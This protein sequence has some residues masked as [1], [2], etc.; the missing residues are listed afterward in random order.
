[1]RTVI[2]GAGAA[3]IS[4]ADELAK[5][6]PWE[7]ITVVARDEFP[8]SRCMLH[9]YLEG[10]REKGQLTFVEE[11]FFAKRGIIFR[12]SEDVLSI[13]PKDRSV[14]TNKGSVFYDKLLIAAGS[15]YFIPPIPNF[16]TATNVYGFRNLKDVVLLKK[17]CK[18]GKSVVIIGSGLI[19]MDIA[20]ACSGMGMDIVVV[21][22]AKRIMPLQTD[23]IS[24]RRYQK[25]FEQSGVRFRL[26]V[27]A[28]DTVVDQEG[29][30]RQIILSDG[31]VLACD[32]VVVA[33]GVHPNVS[34]IG[35]AD[36]FINRGIQVDE[37]MKTSQEDIYA[38]GDIT[39]LSGIWSN[40]VEQGRIAAVNM[41][42]GHEAYTERFCNKNISN[43]FGLSMLSVGSVSSDGGNYTILT[44]ETPQKYKKLVLKDDC[45]VGALFQGDLRGTGIWQYLIKNRINVK[46]IEKDLFNISIADFHCFDEDVRKKRMHSV[47]RLI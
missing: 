2:I 27:G 44:Q 14:K 8:Y 29:N 35:G 24:S 47:M 30:I 18:A 33:A 46:A 5:R 22:M 11:D 40:A 31:S 36:I 23:E 28:S 25:L 6:K 16:R 15:C 13:N 42:G 3:G 32:F 7:D 10:K 20:Y 45:I 37:Y 39:G 17:I 9:Y 43:F 21:E 38:A 12:G 34:V 41:A 19:G 4:A 1:M 26:G